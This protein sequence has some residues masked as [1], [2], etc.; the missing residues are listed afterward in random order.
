MAFTRH[1]SKY[2]QDWKESRNRKPLVLRGARQVGK[3][4]IIGQ[5]AKSYKH[6]IALNL[7]KPAHIFFF[8]NYNDVKT[9]VDALLLSHKIPSNNL[10]NTILFID[11]IQESPKAIHLLRFFH[12]EIPEL[13]VVAAGSLL[14]FAMRHIRGFPVGRIEFLQLYPLNFSEYLDAID[15][16]AALEQLGQIPVNLFAHN[17]LLELFNRYAIIGGMP[18]VIKVYLQNNSISDLPKI[19]ESIWGAY[20]NDV[21]K[22]T[23]NELERKVIK[24][25]M[26][27]AHLYVD[28][29]IKFQNFGNSNY[30]S[31]EVGE[32]MRHLDDARI[33][34]LIYPTTNV[35]IPI[36]PDLRKS[37]KLQLLDTGLLN[38]TLEIQSQLLAL[39]DLDNAYKG[40]I[41][42]HLITQELM[43]L[44]TISHK[45]PAFWVREKK[46]ASAEVDIAFSYDGKIIPIEIKSGSTGS[47][48]SLHQ[49][50]EQS[51]HPYAIRIYAGEFKIEKAK[52]PGRFPYLLMNLPYYLSTKL[53]QYIEYFLNEYKFK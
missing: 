3:T 31:R 7:E 46:Q 43:S 44:N 8:D 53:P 27:S 16:S 21:E 10:K 6:S 32:A 19:Y 40:A 51:E 36:R 39:N 47:L 52:T 15:H 4:T 23:D 18:E 22:Y 20:K 34:Q 5:F 12:E 48:K 14:E 30:R 11:E 25:I 29:R 33:I 37:P 42:P 41:I 1:I 24:H 26:A 50:I 49:F 17:I 38:H 28:Q 9:I 45:K 35:T 2:L 13:H